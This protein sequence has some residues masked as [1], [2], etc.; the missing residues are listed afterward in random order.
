MTA[1]MCK[2]VGFC[3]VLTGVV[4]LFFVPQI[5]EPAYVYFVMVYS[6]GLILGG[7]NMYYT[8]QK[9]DGETE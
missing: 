4:S 3:C 9:R 7:T 1:S 5:I 8:D 2:L 6:I